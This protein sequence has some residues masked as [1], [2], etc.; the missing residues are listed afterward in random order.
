[1]GVCPGCLTDVKETT[2]VE[3]LQVIHILT[4]F[5]NPVI[6]KVFEYLTKMVFMFLGVLTG[7][8]QVIYVLTGECQAQ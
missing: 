2:I 7:N 4:G 1:M 8:E 5:E 3:R 6:L